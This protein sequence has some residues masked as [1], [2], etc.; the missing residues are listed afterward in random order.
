MEP[1]KN[2]VEQYEDKQ[3]KAFAKPADG[4]KQY[5]LQ[6]DS[7]D[8]IFGK[9]RELNETRT[10]DNK[11]ITCSIGKYD[12]EKSKHI[13]YETYNVESG[14]LA[15]KIYL[16]LPRVKPEE[17]KNLTTNLKAKGVKFDFEKKA[18]YVTEDRKNE[19]PEYLQPE[20]QL[21]NNNPTSESIKESDIQ[22]ISEDN[23]LQKEE[24]DSVEHNEDK[25]YKAFAKPVD[26]SKPYVLQEDS[27]DEIFKKVR[28]WNETRTDNKFIT[29]SIG[30]Y[31]AEKAKYINYETYNVE[32]GKLAEKL[33]LK[34]PRVK[35]E[36][37]KNLT[38]ELK[39]K[40]VRFDFEKK[41]WYVTEDRK[42]EFPEYLQPE[43]Q[44]AVKNESP[45]ASSGGAFANFEQNTYDYAALERE[46]TENIGDRDVPDVPEEKAVVIHQAEKEGL[47]QEQIDLLS[48]PEF[49][50]AQATEIRY[51]FTDGLSMEQVLNYAKPEL[52]TGQMDIYRYGQIHGIK[53]E[54]LESIVQSDGKWADHRR[55][56][57]QLIGQNRQKIAQEFTSKG[58]RVSPELVKKM[59]QLNHITKKENTLKDV[60]DS[61]KKLEQI[62]NTE[63][64]EIVRDIGNELKTQQL[65]KAVPIPE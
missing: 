4:S 33:Y 38:T 25:Q 19:F 61:Y 39:A 3:Y 34:L 62:E 45:Q 5:V 46:L 1:S 37:F 2:P 50:K 13:N 53:P 11:F 7:T 12:A 21:I 32:S 40:G 23:T 59:E 18:W 47:S 8:E 44:E 22:D 20:E 27:T 57:D 15:E 31:D 16:K 10:E 56:T 60:C 48:K 55:A 49:S 65:E 54:V 58:F 9:V 30:K 51:G 43:E 14:M 29:C 41:A 17:F 42:N 28:E 63:C 6:G 64:K 26:G 35:P 24:R 36:E 52:S